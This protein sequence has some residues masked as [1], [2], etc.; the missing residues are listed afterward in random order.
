MEKLEPCPFCG[1]DL[2]PWFS[3]RGAVWPSKVRCTTCAA[4][5]PLGNTKRSAVDRWNDISRIVH[6]TSEAEAA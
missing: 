6:G 3:D 2:G 4:E 1:S 5:G